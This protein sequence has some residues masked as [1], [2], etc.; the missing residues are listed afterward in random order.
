MKI[1]RFDV[2]ELKDG[3]SATILDIKD[4]QHYF[5]DIVNPYGIT[6]DR[7]SISEEDINKIIFTKEKVR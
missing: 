3:N 1:K 2:V 5:V 7:T 4:K 6:L